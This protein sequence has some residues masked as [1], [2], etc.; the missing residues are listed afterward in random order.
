MGNAQVFSI[1]DYAANVIDLT[2]DVEL[3]FDATD[4]LEI[5]DVLAL[6]DSAFQKNYTVQEYQKQTFWGK[7]QVINNSI[8]PIEKFISYCGNLDAVAT[9]FVT[10][11]DVS[12]AKVSGL[13]SYQLSKKTSDKRNIS[14]LKLKPGESVTIFYKSLVSGNYVRTHP[15]EMTLTDR[16]FFFKSTQTEF[17][18]VGGMFGILTIMFILSLILYLAFFDSSFL[19]FSLTLLSLILSQALNYQ[20]V[21]TYILPPIDFMGNR[22]QNISRIVLVLSFSGLIDSLLRLKINTPRIR[23]IFWGLAITVCAIML[24]SV[25]TDTIK[26]YRVS[27][28]SL[29]TWIVVTTI[30][31][32]IEAIKRKGEALIVLLSVIALASG[33]FIVLLS[34]T[35]VIPKTWL[36]AHAYP[37]GSIIFVTLVLVSLWIR[38]RRIQF[39]KMEA[40]EEALKASREKERIVK[41]QNVLLEENIKERTRELVEQ[42]DASDKLLLNILPLDT[43]KELRDKGSTTARE[44]KNVSILFADIC[45]FTTLCEQLTPADL[46]ESIDKYFTAFDDITAKHGLEKIKTI[47]DA[48]VAVGNMP[49]GNRAKARNVVAAGLEMI[50]FCKQQNKTATTG[51]PLC[52]RVGVHTGNVVAGVVGSKKFQYDIWGDAV[53]IAARMEQS[54]SANKLNI[55]SATHRLVKDDFSFIKRGTIEAKNKGN[56]EMFFAEPLAF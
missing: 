6:P 29:I 12:E 20:L 28:F 55:S 38:I 3:Y 46:V 34:I 48:Y 15:N 2:Q 18:F 13:F 1:S 14:V 35:H 49:I 54:S 22:M 4:S 27:S 16:T 39:D 42:K 9:Y 24:A 44:Y 30:V 17:L 36:S 52:I 31:I 51:I 37:I 5:Q 11:E 21:Q 26:A 53:N 50:D 41:K 8:Q 56:L 33:G 43:A 32:S 7:I 23:T 45:N 10:N 19:F 47:G 25:L 40:K